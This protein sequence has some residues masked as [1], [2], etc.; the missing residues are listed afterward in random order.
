[1]SEAAARI[2]RAIGE[3]GPITF[4]E[5]MEHALYGPGGF[6]EEPPI[7]ADGHFVTSPHVHPIFAELLLRGLVELWEELGRPDPLTLVEVGA[8][9]GTL[10]RDLLRLAGEREHPRIDYVAVDRSRGSRVALA[11]VTGR[12]EE[13]LRGVGTLDGAV[14]FANELLDNL[15]FRRVRRTGG[16]L[17]EVRVGLEDA[18]FVEV[19]APCDPELASSIAGLQESGEITVPVGAFRFVDDLAATLL[20]GF[21]LLI[22]YG[23]EGGP[24]GE[25]HGYRGHVV[26]EDVLR[27]PGSADI[28]AGV[29]LGAIAG[30]AEE[31][32]L[33]SIGLSSQR[34]ALFS[35]GFG[36]WS[37]SQRDRQSRLISGGAGAA[38]T[39]VWQ[40]LHRASFLADPAALGRL[41]WLV[42]GTPRLGPP[43]FLTDPG[44]ATDRRTD[45]PS[46]DPGTG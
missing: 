26:Q 29:D 33:R 1:V 45:R 7:G 13:G 23:S 22:D 11:E 25:V 20:R 4:A 18:R 5:F 32:G 40:G 30:R 35:L 2:R 10:A 37:A 31:K 38:A 14:V 44:P 36:E 39:R 15:P 43:V 16:R 27:D 8:G 24:A 34:E 42:L 46:F 9:D 3:R 28:T 21:A 41:R 12:V 17:E 19:L 6:Y